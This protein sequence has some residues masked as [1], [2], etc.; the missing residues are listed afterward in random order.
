MH[1]LAMALADM[2]CLAAIGLFVYGAG[3]R[4]RI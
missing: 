3:T 4:H 1:N 2:I